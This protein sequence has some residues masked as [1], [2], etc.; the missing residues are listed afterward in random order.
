M[1]VGRNQWNKLGRHLYF[2]ACAS[3][4]YRVDVG[5]E[6]LGWPNQDYLA[7]AMYWTIDG[8]ISSA[9]LL[10]NSW[11]DWYHEPDTLWFWSGNE[12]DGV[13]SNKYDGRSL[14]AHEF[15]HTV[16][17]NHSDLP[18]VMHAY[19]WAGVPRFLLSDHDKEGMSQYPVR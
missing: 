6:D 13:P 18:D 10:F 1:N 17:L 15:G 11:P 9:D 3:G 4:P 8:K 16:A 7:V 12:T 19:F 14:A 2:C 5:Y